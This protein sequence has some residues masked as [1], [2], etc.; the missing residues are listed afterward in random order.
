MNNWTARAP[1]ASAPPPPPLTALQSSGRTSPSLTL[2]DDAASMAAAR[3]SASPPAESERAVTGVAASQSV[4]AAS[5]AV[6]RVASEFQALERLRDAG[7]GGSVVAEKLKEI[8]LAVARLPEEVRGL[9]VN[10]VED[11]A[12]EIEITSQIAQKEADLAW[13][14]AELEALKKK[15]RRLAAARAERSRVCDACGQR[16]DAP[17]ERCDGFGGPRYCGDACRKKHWL[18]EHRDACAAGATVIT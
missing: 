11:R 10:L 12:D 5:S 9:V 3:A 13:R 7:Y 2:S 8:R 4:E 14:T 1:A 18:A 17:L 15:S 16:P 6:A